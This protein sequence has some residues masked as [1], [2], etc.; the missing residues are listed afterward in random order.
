MAKQVAGKV[1]FALGGLGGFNAH[2]VGFLQAARKLGVQPSIIT[3]TSG[4]IGWVAEWLEGKDLEPD[5]L[6][7]IAS[8]NKFPPPFDWLNTLW[9]SWFGDPGVFRPAVNEYWARWFSPLT[10]PHPKEL[11]DRLLPAQVY[12]PLR[13]R[14]DLER[15]AQTLNKSDIPVAFNTFH[16][17][18]GMAYLHI[19]KAAQDFLGVRFGEI[20][21][22]EKYLPIT[23]EAVAGALWLYF[24][25]FNPKD[26]PH[27]LVD[28]AY[29]RQFI[30]SELHMCDRLYAV[31]PQNSRW[32]GTLPENYFETQDFTTELWFNS[33]Y[34]AEVAQMA[35]VNKLVRQGK[36][37][38][39]DFHE[40]EL[41][42]I[43]VEHQ[44]GYFQYF[45]E[46]KSVY[47]NSL[48]ASTRLLE[49]HEFA[50][51]AKKPARELAAT[52]G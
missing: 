45:V 3:C 34:S 26:N 16:P 14:D 50:K 33:S 23:T 20:G 47:D 21:G 7:Q 4:M 51:P 22:R 27:G 5:L 6:K 49:E 28:G 24:Y 46:E 2:G 32:I 31:R 11:V 30:I 43:Q 13:A 39:A 8:D 9:I 41:L 35:I 37:S 48:K 44:Y 40:V 17:K 36:L 12:V 42:E 19:N 10:S 38:T 18:T 52:G 25:G 15:I 1:G 29:N